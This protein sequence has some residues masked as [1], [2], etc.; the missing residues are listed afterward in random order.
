MSQRAKVT[1]TIFIPSVRNISSL[2]CNLKTL[3]FVRLYETL[4]S[5]EP[6]TRVKQPYP[7]WCLRFWKIIQTYQNLL[8]F[9]YWEWTQGAEIAVLLLLFLPIRKIPYAMTGMTDFFNVPLIYSKWR[10]Y[11]GPHFSK[12]SEKFSVL[13][14]ETSCNHLMS[15]MMWDIALCSTVTSIFQSRNFIWSIQYCKES[16]CFFVWGGNVERMGERGKGT[17]RKNSPRKKE[18][19]NY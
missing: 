12:E 4:A 13:L 1:S 16:S 7:L 17:C 6:L 15:S 3:K 10:A 18:R 2:Y 11:F 9:L 14:K 19:L 8:V 5:Q